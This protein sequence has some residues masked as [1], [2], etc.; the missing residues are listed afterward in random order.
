MRPLLTCSLL[1]L[2][3][4]PT[5]IP[6]VETPRQTVTPN[7]IADDVSPDTADSSPEPDYAP[8]VYD[9][10]TWRILAARPDFQGAAHTEV[11]KIIVDMQDG[12]R[13]YFTQSNHWDLHYAFVRR[14]IDPTADHATF[15]VR[16]YRRADRRFLLG[17]VVHYLDGDLWALEMVPGDT[18]SAERL[19]RFFELVKS[20]V[21]F[22]DRLRFRPLSALHE[23]RLAELGER[24]PRLGSEELM[25]HVRY[26]PVV[27]GLTFGTLRFVAAGEDPN[28][29]TP[30]DLLVLEQVPEELPRCAGVITAQLQAPLAHIAV[31]AHQRGTPDMAL[32]DAFHNPDLRALQDQV[33]RLDVAPQDFHLTAATRSEAE[34][35][36]VARRPTQ[37]F[38]PPLDASARA[39]REVSDLS[40]SDVD[41]VGAK[42]AQLG[43][44]NS[45][46]GEVVTPGGFAIPFARYIEHL[47]P[48]SAGI[49]AMLHDAGFRGNAADRARALAQLRQMIQTREVNATLLRDV[50]RRIHGF[51]ARRVILRSSTNAEDLVGFN[52]AGLYESVVIAGDADDT[53]IADAL[54]KV[55]ASVWLL[56]AHDEREWYRIDH[57]RVAMGVLVQP[58]VADVVGSGVAITKNPY[59]EGR[60]GVFL[61]IQSG[62]RVTDARGDE[63]PEQFIVYTWMD[64]PEPQLISRSSITHGQPILSD[65]DAVALAQILRRIDDAMAP[66]YQGG[67]NAVDVEFLVTSGAHRFVIVQARPYTVEYTE[68]QRYRY[69]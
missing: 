12:D 40:S 55:W 28:V 17:S 30:S 29:F 8:E 56:R 27:T 53:A 44:V 67:A 46:G 32:R 10:R 5:P 21:Y 36:W 58:F 49:D 42:A 1:L 22:G 23:S 41:T 34:Q 3:A 13:S 39:I 11:V 14:F 26:Q 63:I 48:F 62:A 45:L 50:T 2:S 4:C 43:A 24:V 59:D 38:V 51:H 69:E 65:S 47:R 60:P 18:M 61:N 64:P 37:P 66:L 33:V 31:L 6:R 19:A 25:A 68:G 9:E 57:R 52:G 35:S 54:R 7:A 16:Q 20:H 15:N